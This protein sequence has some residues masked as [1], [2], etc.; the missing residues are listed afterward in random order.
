MHAAVT[1]SSRTHFLLAAAE[2][3][4]GEIDAASYIAGAAPDRVTTWAAC[5]TAFLDE[6]LTG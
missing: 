1:V 5:V 3:V 6:H 4:P 2:H